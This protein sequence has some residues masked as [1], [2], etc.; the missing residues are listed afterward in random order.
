LSVTDCDNEEAFV[1]YHTIVKA[2]FLERPNRFIAYC[3][4]DGKR[5]KV[6][7]K[8]TGRCQEL[9]LKNA[10][11]FLEESQNENRSTKFDLI[12]VEKG[13]RLINM[14]SQAPNKVVLEWLEASEIFQNIV[15]IKPEC[16]YGNSRFDFYVETDTEKIFIEVKGVTRE[17]DSIVCFPDAPSERAI[18]HV[19]ELVKAKKQG[20]RSIVL[21]VVQMEEAS[22]FTPD[23]ERHPAFCE[24]L[25][26]ASKA[27]VE[28]MA[29]TCHV[30]PDSLTIKE[31]LPV[32][33]TGEKPELLQESFAR[34]ASW[35][36]INKRSLPWR[37][38]PTPYH[39]WVSEIMLQQTRVEAVKPYFKRFMDSLPTISDLSQAKEDVLLKL[40][41][42]LGYYNRVRNLQKAAQVIETQYHGEMPKDY[43]ALLQLPGIGS[44]TAGAI[45]S[46][47]FGLPFPAVDG[48]VLRV[49]SRLRMDEREIT[50]TKVKAAVEQEVSFAMRDLCQKGKLAPGVINQSLMELGA[51]VCLPNGAPLC[52]QCPIA[53]LCR[54]YAANT[55]MEY[56]KKAAKKARVIETKT[57]LILKDEEKV[58]LHKRPQKGLLAGLYELPMIEG[59]LTKKQVIAFLKGNGLQP[60]FVKSLP[61]AKHIFTHKEWH[62]TGYEIK[63]DEL[64]PK[65][66]IGEVTDWIY[67]LGKDIEKQY[68]IPSAFETYY[69]Y[70]GIAQGKKKF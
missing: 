21:F 65:K 53:K 33:L 46:I 11:V 1:R 67:A 4:I 60:I 26:E 70:L 57:V 17:A 58:A 6:H 13:N 37:E 48:N 59:K 10:T 24:A 31:S 25:K 22:F 62:M 39:V 36:E 18:K 64:S 45:S 63:V 68:P 55:V 38:E 42:G 49:L 16:V 54:A 20:Y 12:A 69:E 52:E 3:D 47:A 61:S 30:T 29:Y 5:E 8:N 2:S 27:G 50:D 40:W 15:T 43:E 51:C 34:L 44:Y 7:V 32:S 14:D 41:E 19:E 23:T 56:P 35:Y 66:P 28:I 9:L